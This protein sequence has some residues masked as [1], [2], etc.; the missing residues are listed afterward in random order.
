MYQLTGEA[1]TSIARR[2]REPHLPDI[3]KRL[4]TARA[5]CVVDIAQPDA[6]AA[7]RLC[8]GKH[9]QQPSPDQARG[10]VTEQL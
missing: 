5:C 4:V 9:S 8:I 6:M 3:S 10:L 2:Q 1:S 7:A